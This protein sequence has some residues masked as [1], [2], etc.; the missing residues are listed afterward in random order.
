MFLIGEAYFRFFHAESTSFVSLSHANWL[1]RY[2]QNNSQGYRDREWQSSD[3]TGR[4]VVV[5]IGDSFT[6]GHGI[7]SV[8]DR[9]T[10]VLGI[11]LGDDYAVVNLGI[12]GSATRQQLEAVQNFDLASPNVIV[13]QYFLNDIEFAAQQHGQRPPITPPPAIA[14]ES[15]LLNFLYFRTV[16][17]EFDY[18]AWLYSQYDNAAVW[19]DHRQ[20]LDA[21]AAYAESIDAELIVLIYPNMLDPMAS[22]PY[23]DRVAQELEA[24]GQTQVIKLFDA[25][26]AWPVGTPIIVSPQDAHPSVEFN[27]YVAE[28][29]YNLYFTDTTAED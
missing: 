20:E 13:W 11:L 1:S 8:E 16:R 17:I 24:T 19:E 2:V 12:S 18:F 6:A 9:W 15:Y 4:K 28:T 10:N 3:F 14:Q 26:A 5:A 7:N 27:H 25:V 29:I 21:V 22:I 23:V